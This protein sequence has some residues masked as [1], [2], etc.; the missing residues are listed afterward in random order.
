MQQTTDTINS[1]VAKIAS[2]RN[3]PALWDEVY[4]LKGIDDLAFALTSGKSKA[5]L[6][7]DSSQL[8]VG[9]W[10][11]LLVIATN[12]SVRGGLEANAKESNAALYRVLEYEVP[13]STDRLGHT[14]DAQ[15]ILNELANNYGY[16]GAVEAKWLGMHPLEAEARVHRVQAR[17]RERFKATEAERFWV[18]GITAILCGAELA[19][20]L[21]LATFN[22]ST[23]ITFLERVFMEN[24]QHIEGSGAGLHKAV[25]V[26]NIIAGFCNDPKHFVLRVETVA[27]G[28]GKPVATSSNASE[29]RGIADICARISTDPSIV[30]LSSRVLHE[31][32][33]RHE[34]QSELLVDE[35]KKK[36]GA[37]RVKLTL[38]AGTPLSRARAQEYVYEMDRNHP[39]LRDLFS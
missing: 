6:A 39:D 27:Q 12:K 34:Y 18:A 23:M 7:R 29:F 10:N 17:V 26:T 36:F 14:E 8:H 5:R 2:G 38:T 16:A 22:L 31:Y 32:C 1:I 35:L 25:N 3:M 28:K 21:E 37:K 15:A 33:R 19:N 20:E 4:L 24:R 13:P 9:T 30:Q 11:T